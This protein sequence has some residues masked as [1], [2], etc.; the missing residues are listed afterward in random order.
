M[1]SEKRERGIKEIFRVL[2]NN[3]AFVVLDTIKEEGIS[4]LN[5]SM[6]QLFSEIEWGFIK[7]GFLS[8]QLAFIRGIAKKSI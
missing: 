1:S 6:K 3:G 8:P 4:I 2:K 5:N 7:T